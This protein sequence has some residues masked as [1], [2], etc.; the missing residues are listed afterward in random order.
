VGG[1]FPREKDTRFAGVALRWNF[2]QR[3]HD[4]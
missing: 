4:F 1:D 2:P 3:L